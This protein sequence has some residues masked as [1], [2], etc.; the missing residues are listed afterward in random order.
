MDFQ[1]HHKHFCFCS[2]VPSDIKKKENDILKV[3]NCTTEAIGE[4]S[5]C[6]GTTFDANKYRHRHTSNT[7]FSFNSQGIDGKLSSTALPPNIVP[8]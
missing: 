2:R 4:E 6:D 7:I 8:P 3:V 5:L 1:S